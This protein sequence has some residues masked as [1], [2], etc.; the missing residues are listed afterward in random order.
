MIVMIVIKKKIRQAKE[1]ESDG[2]NGRSGC[3][4]S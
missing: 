1:V 2:G 3:C 4:F